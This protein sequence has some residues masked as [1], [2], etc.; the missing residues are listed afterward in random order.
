MTSGRAT[1]PAATGHTAPPSPGGCGKVIGLLAARAPRVERA[2]KKIARTR[3]SGRGRDSPTAARA[4]SW[5]P[6]HGGLRDRRRKDDHGRAGR[7]GV[8]QGRAILVMVPT[9]DLLVQTAQA[10]PRVGRNGPMAAV[11]SLAKDE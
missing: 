5:A 10:W 2:L 3:G 1:W 9:L 8:L 11:C 4:R 7:A 6:W